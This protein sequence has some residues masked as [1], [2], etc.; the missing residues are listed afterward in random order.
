MAKGDWQVWHTFEGPDRWQVGRVKNTAKKPTGW[1]D[2]EW[3]FDGVG[4]TIEGFKERFYSLDE[5]E[6]AAWHM[7][8]Y[9]PTKR[10]KR[11][12]SDENN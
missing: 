11:S 9:F 12:K 5:A 2:I 6:G 4:K 7:N 10:R 1:K 8:E 3:A